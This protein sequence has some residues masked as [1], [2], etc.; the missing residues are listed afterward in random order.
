MTKI[1]IIGAGLSGLSVANLLNKSAEITIFE[2]A[3]GVSGRLATRRAGAYYF[4]HGAQYFTARTKQFQDFIAPLIKEGIIK[5]WDARCIKF[6]GK[7]IIESNIFDNNEPRYVGISGMN[8]IGKF[9]AKDLNVHIEKKII[10]L[11]H[12]DTWHLTDD[13]GQVYSGFDWVICTTPSPQ[14]LHLLPQSFAYYSAIK[15]VKMRACFALM[16]G[17]TKPPLLSLE[18]AYCTGS[19]LSWVSSGSNKKN[20]KNHFTLIVHSSEKYAQE[21][22]NDDHTDVI[23]HLIKEASR[24]TEFDL[25]IAEYKNLHRWRYAN[26]ENRGAVSDVFLDA[27]KNLAACGDWCFGG[28]VE[29]AFLSA[30]NLASNIRKY[31]L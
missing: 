21:H 13:Q 18:A 12:H 22:I 27:N 28:R 24:I 15:A 31:L 30:Y 3:R 4:D 29:G 5:E 6:E 7:K 1:A 26:I 19:D 8:Q 14:A 25:N 16:L 2:K 23:E 11:N 20:S 17:F 10:S 9:L